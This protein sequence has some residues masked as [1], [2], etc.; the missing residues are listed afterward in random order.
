MAGWRE[1][2]VSGKSVI[3]EGKRMSFQKAAILEFNDPCHHI[4]YKEKL[5]PLMKEPLDQ[6]QKEKIREGFMKIWELDMQIQ[7]ARMTAMMKNRWLLSSLQKKEFE[8]WLGNLAE[9]ELG[10]I[11]RM[12][13]GRVIM[14]RSKDGSKYW[15]RKDAEWPRRKDA[16]VSFEVFEEVSRKEKEEAFM[17]MLE[18][19]EKLK[20]LEI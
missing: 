18:L 11:E 15:I 10:R 14:V 1:Y 5:G 4:A 20:K 2:K 12:P 16:P 8:E 9:N 19:M 7:K 6:Q 13:A 3:L 17:R